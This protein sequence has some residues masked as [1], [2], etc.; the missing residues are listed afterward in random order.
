MAGFVGLTGKIKQKTVTPTNPGFFMVDAGD[1]EK[2][3]GVLVEDIAG[4]DSIPLYQRDNCRIVHVKDVGVFVYTGASLSTGWTS[5]GNWSELGANTSIPATDLSVSATTT[6][7]TI[8][9]DNGTTGDAA[10]IPAASTTQAGVMTKANFDKLGTI[11]SGAQVNV[12]TDLSNTPTS[13]S[14]VVQATNGALTGTPTSLPAATTSNAGVMSA[15]DKTKLDSIAANAKD[16]PDWGDIGGTLSNQTDLQAALDAKVDDSEKGANNGVATLDATGKVPASQLN[17]TGMTYKGTWNANT[18]TPPLT[19]GSGTTGDTYAVSVAGTHNF[20]SGA[21]TF[22]A[23]DFVVYNGTIWE[24][25]PSASAVTSVNSQTG[26]VVIDKTGVGLGNVDNVADA[27]KPV[28][29]PQETRIQVVETSLA[30]HAADDT[31]L[32]GDERAAI[33]AAPNA[34]TAA[35]PFITED[36]LEARLG[37]SDV[38]D[39]TKDVYDTNDDGKVDAADLADVATVALEAAKLDD[40]SHEATAEEVRDHIDSTSVH[41]STDERNAINNT[42]NTPNTS[43][44]FATLQDLTDAGVDG[45]VS[46]VTTEAL[47]PK[48]DIFGWKTTTTFPIGTTLETLIKEIITVYN[49][50]VF[51]T[52]TIDGVSYSTIEAGSTIAFTDINVGWSVD[53]EGDAFLDLRFTGY[54]ASNSQVLLSATPSGTG[55]SGTIPNAESVVATINSGSSQTYTWTVYGRDAD[56]NQYNISRT[57]SARYARFW[58]TTTQA[59]GMTS[60]LARSQVNGGSQLDTN[61]AG[62]LPQMTLTAGHYLWLCQPVSW[63]TVIITDNGFP[64]SWESPETFS[65]Q[66]PNGQLISYYAY[67]TTNTGLEDI[68]PTIV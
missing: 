33:D 27:N 20:G 5:S 38:G 26:A 29:G 15:A 58:V 43:N 3:L 6:T 14:V 36:D 46:A 12:K 32:S 25:A 28:S 42:P 31:H 54:N 56:N 68:I 49:P 50:P 8:T 61:K 17:V 7:V 53:T 67:R 1:V 40:G 60:A 10:V 37:T 57:V 44:P 9:P 24:K 11:A 55:W 30:S 2:G 21:I 59:S 45:L 39:M 19:D 16:D 13:V 64:M 48:V 4:R 23:G 47:T 51:S 22:G 63:G 62:T 35:N 66:L 41:L 65:L 52:F 18:D 34:P